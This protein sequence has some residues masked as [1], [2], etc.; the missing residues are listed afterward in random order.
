[1]AFF[2]NKPTVR[3]ALLAACVLIASPV[4]AVETERN[5]LGMELVLIPAG[6]FLM[7]SDETAATMSQVYPALPGERFEQ[8]QDEAPVRKV[9]ITRP[10]WMAKHELTVGQFRRFIEAS[11]YQPQSVADGTGGYG[12]R[13]GYDPATTRRG[14]AFEG[15]DP[16]Y[17]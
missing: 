15:R 4:S 6:E 7:G 1:M 5:S 17:S 3:L 8:F 9:R 12:W 11:G 13:A 2:A 14:D 10:L 16:R